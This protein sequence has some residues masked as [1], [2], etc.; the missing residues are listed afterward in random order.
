MAADA[1]TRNAIGDL[2]V[3][4]NAEEW[5]AWVSASATRNHVLDNPLLDWLERH[6]EAK[7]YE[8]D[9]EDAIDPRTDFLT[10]IFAQGAAFEEAIV[11]HLGTLV[12]VHVPEGAEQ[13]YEARRD[14]A[15]AEATFEA[16][17]RGEP[18]IFQGVLRDAESRVYGAVAHGAASVTW[19]GRATVLAAARRARPTPHR[20]VGRDM[21]TDP[22]RCGQ[23]GRQRT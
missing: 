18:V 1:L 19:N 22:G 10:F 8:R 6:G 4:T 17:R 11:R 20:T 21:P 13:G 2:V 14:L 7:G 3:P 9:G 23:R 5:D 12:E 16:M 15:V